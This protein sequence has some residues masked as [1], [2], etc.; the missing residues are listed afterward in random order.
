MLKDCALRNS[1][2]HSPFIF[3]HFSALSCKLGIVQVRIEATLCK[4]RI[5]ISL[6]DDVY[7]LHDKNDIRLLDGHLR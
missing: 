4:Q 1:L 2:K 3:I 5:V 6:F 7:I